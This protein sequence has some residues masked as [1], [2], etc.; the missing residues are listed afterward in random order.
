MIKV[1]I[2]GDTHIPTRARKIPKI[3]E[4]IIQSNKPYQ[5]VFFTGD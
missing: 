1:L 3:M 4:E 2:T 5:A